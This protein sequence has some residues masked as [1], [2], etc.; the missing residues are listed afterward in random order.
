MIPD[1]S[2]LI[3]NTFAPGGEK[4][5]FFQSVISVVTRTG[6]VSTPIGGI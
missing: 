3:G 6:L 4:K 1:L 2:K 5:D